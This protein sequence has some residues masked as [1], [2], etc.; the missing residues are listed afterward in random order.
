M[1]TQE[2]LGL[3]LSA[4]L[5]LSVYS[6]FLYKDN[7]FFHIAEHLALAVAL[8]NATVVSVKSLYDIAWEPAIV[9]GQDPVFWIGVLV[10]SGLTMARLFPKYGWVSR[11]PLAFIVGS[12]I[13]L[14]LRG[15]VETQLLGNLRAVVIPLTG[16][17]FTPIDNIVTLIMCGSTVAYFLFTREHKGAMG[18]VSKIGRYS[19]MVGFG[20]Q[21]GSVTIDRISSLGS[22]LITVLKAVG[23]A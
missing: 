6:M 7:P 16:G 1:L 20:A 11:W 5:I 12:G 15:A 3:Y 17:R 2:T 8:A 13:G 10:F 4:V 22:I 14:G 23:L 9:K 21:F 18:I 19:M